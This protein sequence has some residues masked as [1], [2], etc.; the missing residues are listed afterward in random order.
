MFHVLVEGNR[1]LS[2]INYEAS[3]PEGVK[4]FPIS[5]EQYESLNSKTHYFDAV[6]GEL[7]LM[8]KDFEN[9][10]L[11]RLAKTNG[12]AYLAETDWKVL[13]HLREKTLGLATTLSEEELL[14]L[15]Q[16]R[17]E[18]AASISR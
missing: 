12:K 4:S 2:I 8:P 1:V 18:V 5:S 6:K 13:R 15:E 7:V 17:H 14:A 10:K 11:E 16:K 9:H 3:I